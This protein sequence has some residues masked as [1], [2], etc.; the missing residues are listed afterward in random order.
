[1]SSFRYITAFTKYL[2]TIYNEC[3][4]INIHLIHKEIK[5]RNKEKLN[6]IKNILC[7]EFGETQIS[8]KALN[9][10]AYSIYDDAFSADGEIADIWRCLEYFYDEEDND[11]NEKSDNVIREVIDLMEDNYITAQLLYE[12]STDS[13]ED[14]FIWIR[15][16]EYNSEW[17]TKEQINELKSCASHLKEFIS[18][19]DYL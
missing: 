4:K 9:E 11:F 10:C 1:M 7:E 17:L 2:L 19:W 15:L 14:P 12:Y 8:K 3:S 18:N 16:L 13:C 6:K 5:M